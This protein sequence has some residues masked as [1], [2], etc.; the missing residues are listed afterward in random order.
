MG[1]AQAV[2]ALIAVQLCLGG[3]PAGVPDGIAVLDIEI[4]A[5]AVQRHGIV[6][7]TGQA[8]QLGVFYKKLYPP[9]VL[10]TKEKKPSIPR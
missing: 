3:L 7:V 9:E 2:A 1:I 8:E 4:V 10:E 5:V 6:A